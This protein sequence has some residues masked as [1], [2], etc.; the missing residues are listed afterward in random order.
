MRH[1]LPLLAIP[2]AMLAGLR[3]GLLVC[4]LAGL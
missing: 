2:L 3:F 4:Q 1:A